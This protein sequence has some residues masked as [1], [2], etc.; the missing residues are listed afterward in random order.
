[1]STKTTT[2]SKSI[3]QAV[4]EAYAARVD[5]GGCGCGCGPEADSPA[6]EAHNDA[7]LRMGYSAHDVEAVPEGANLGLGCGA[8]LQHGRPAEGETIL[9]L[10]SGAGFDA[11]L[12]AQAVGSEGRVIGVDM[13]PEMIAKARENATKAG[14]ENVEFRQGFIEELPVE[15]DTVDLVISNCVINL[16]PDKQAVFNE[17]FRVLR[18]GGRIAVSDIVLTQ[19]LPQAI[20]DN[21]AAYVGCVAG[22]S[23]LDDYV[24]M[25]SKAGFEQ[26]EVVES[27]PAVDAL[28]EDDVVVKSVLEE[29]GVDNVD[30]LSPLLKNIAGTVLSAKVTARKPATID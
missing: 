10:G 19:E 11:F 26:V 14:V 2:E 16:S 5:S 4:R 8:P 1:M 17:T 18:P 7:A 29:L 22:A 20:G 3:H 15:S 21:L 12:S 23:L 28:P 25:L 24:A 13:T 27:R 6:T 9:D 30:R